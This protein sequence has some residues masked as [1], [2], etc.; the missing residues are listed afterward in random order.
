MKGIWFHIQR[1]CKPFVV[2]IAILLLFSSYSEHKEN[3]AYKSNDNLKEIKGR[4]YYEALEYLVSNPWISDTLRA[5]K[6]DPSFALAVV[7]PELI[8]YSNIQNKIE[9]SALFSLYV[10]YGADYSDFSVGRFQ[11]KP[12]FVMHLERDALLNKV[13]M[14]F[15]GEDIGNDATLQ[16]RLKRIRRLDS[17]LG[18]VRYLILFIKTLDLKFKSV[19]WSGTEDKLKFY[20]SAY[21][22]GY[23][24][25]EKY[26]RQKVD[27]KFFYPSLLPLHRYC[28]SEISLDYC[29]LKNQIE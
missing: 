18:Q 6:L 5:H 29:R 15:I 21:N 11:M 10:H 1:N 7:F 20:A 24:F 14:P 13:V 19:H 2:C 28:Y 12:S 4:K 3:I 16:S 22:C 9:T 8:R 25:S 17:P 23:W 26:I 27:Q